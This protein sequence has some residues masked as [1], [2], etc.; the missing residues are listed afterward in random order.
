[1]KYFKTHPFKAA[2][3]GACAVAEV[4]PA[5]NRFRGDVLRSLFHFISV[6]M[7]RAVHAKAPIGYP[8]P[9]AKD[10]EECKKQF[11][12]RPMPRLTYKPPPRKEPIQRPV[13]TPKPFNLSSDKRATQSEPRHGLNADDVELSKQ[14]HAR[15]VPQTT[16]AGP[17]SKSRTVSVATPRKYAGPPNLATSDRK[18]PREAARLASEKNAEEMAKQRQALALRKK[19]EKH[20]EDM[21]KAS[22]KSPPPNIEPFHL[23]SEARHEAYRQHLAEQLAKEEEE[24]KRQMLFRAKPVR[25]SDPPTRIH[26]D[27]PATTPRPFPLQSVTR[28]ERWREER[29]LQL[30]A[31]EMERQHLMNIKAIPL[32]KSTYKYSPVTPASQ[33]KRQEEG[34]ERELDSARKKALEAL[35]SAENEMGRNLLGSTLG[36]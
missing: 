3:V 5:R 17:K 21:A 13:T 12:A 25:L 1:M 23:Q 36:S 32:P 19:R 15:P 24:M 26:S 33:K 4:D 14:F 20:Q 7:I 30:D 18:E 16:Y 34:E 35:E 27:R 31:E 11:H 9:E 10:L 2:P 28:H 8:D 22:L 29:R 6:P